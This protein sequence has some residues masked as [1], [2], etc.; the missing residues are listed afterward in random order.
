MPLARRFIKPF[1]KQLR[2][3]GYYEDDLHLIVVLINM[4][5]N[6]FSP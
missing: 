4:A 5:D 6:P 1:E 3:D 2:R